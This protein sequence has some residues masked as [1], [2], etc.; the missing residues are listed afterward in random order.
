MLEDGMAAR[1]EV[2]QAE[3]LP[4]EPNHRQDTDEVRAPYFAEEVRCE[5]LARYGDTF[6]YGSGLSVRTS[7]DA[8]LRARP[9]ENTGTQSARRKLFLISSV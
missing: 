7:L 1:E 4:L 6:L 8:R 9:C 5:L 2:T 3:A